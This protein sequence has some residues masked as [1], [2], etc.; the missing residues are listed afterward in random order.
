MKGWLGFALSMTL[1]FAL[2]TAALAAEDERTR[3]PAGIG[4]LILV[5][6]ITAVV[7]VG[8]YYIRQ[9]QLAAEQERKAKEH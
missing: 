2:P 1:L 3:A 8:A 7:I 6:G 5:L 4:L 9:N